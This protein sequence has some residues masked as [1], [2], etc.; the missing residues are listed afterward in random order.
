MVYKLYFSNF[1]KYIDIVYIN[2]K[3]SFELIRSTSPFRSCRDLHINQGHVLSGFRG[4]F[5]LKCRFCCLGVVRPP[6]GDDCHWKDS[7]ANR[8]QR[9]GHSTPWGGGRGMLHEK[10]PESRG[11]GNKQKTWARV[12]LWF[13]QEGIGQAGGTGLGFASVHNFIRFWCLGAVV[14]DLALGDQGR[15]ILTQLVRAW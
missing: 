10:A 13:L 12:L 3:K 1:K 2:Y 9:R 14:R 15:A 8:S 7:Y 5:I 4:L 11:R 6:D